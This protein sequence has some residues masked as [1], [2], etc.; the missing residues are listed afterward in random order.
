MKL[1][2][3]L[4]AK[5]VFAW[6]KNVFP[7]LLLV[8]S[9]VRQHFKR[10]LV[11]KELEVAD[12]ELEKELARNRANIYESIRN[13]TSRDIVLDVANGTSPELPNSGGDGNK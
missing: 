6:V 5:E 11:K 10:E 7:Q 1:D 9:A 2:W 3:A 13:R 8:F 4:L 12:G